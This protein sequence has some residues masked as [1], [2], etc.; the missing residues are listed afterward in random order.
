[1]AM[2]E[3]GN[4]GVHVTRSEKNNL[5]VLKMPVGSSTDVLLFRDD[6]RLPP[7]IPTL[8]LTSSEQ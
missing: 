6:L 7:Y 5:V 8:Q 4:T 1:M 2:E 3:T